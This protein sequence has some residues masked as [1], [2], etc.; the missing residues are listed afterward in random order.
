MLL[1]GGEG[2]RI[3]P[4]T[5]CLNRYYSEIVFVLRVQEV[6]LVRDIGGDE[7]ALVCIKVFYTANKGL[8]FQKK[9]VR[10]FKL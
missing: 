3:K 4:Y 1:G 5:F 6:V 9:T 8:H 7:E 2:E 10:Q